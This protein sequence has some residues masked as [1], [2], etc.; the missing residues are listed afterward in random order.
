MLF[1][2]Q[3]WSGSNLELS[4]S[5]S[6]KSFHQD[7]L[8]NQSGFTED[9]VY[10]NSTGEVNV[11]RPHI[12][13]V[14]PSQGLLMARTG[15]CSVSI[16]SDDQV[17]LIGGRVDPNPQQQNDEVP[18][19]LIEIFDNINKTW[20]PSQYSLPFA[21]QYCEAEK[22]GNLVVVTGDWARNSNPAEDPSGTVQL[23][24]LDN[25]T[26]FEGTS[27][28]SSDERGLGAMAEANGY[29]YYAGGVR[30]SNGNDA[31][32]KTY[33]Y[34]PQSDQWTRMADMN[35][36][37]A[38]FE[39]VNFHGQLY[40]MGG[41]QG[42]QTWNRQA[43]DYVERYDPSTDT[44]TNLSKLPVARFGWSGTVLNDE[45]VLVGGFNGGAKSEVFH[46]NPIED[47]W[48]KGNDIGY[49]GHFDLI[50]EEI[51]GSIVWAS[52]DSSTY[53]YNSWNQLFSKDTEFQNSS[54]SHSGWVTSPVI[55]LRP[56]QNGRA[57][58]VQFHLQGT[59]T[60]GGELSFQY[61]TS[62]N[63]NSITTK[64][65]QGYDGTINTTFAKGITN[66]NIT[67]SADFIQ[68][69]IKLTVNDMISWDAPD[70]DSMSIKAEHAAFVST[71]PNFFHPNG[72]TIQLQTSHGLFTNGQMYLEIAACNEF[73]STTG[74]WSRLSHDG[75]SFTLSD[76]QNLAPNS[77]GEINS[78]I[79]GETIVNWSIG[80]GE[81]V[82]VS[83]L[84]LKVGTSGEKVTEFVHSSPVEVDN[85]VEVRISNLGTYSPG[86]AVI[87]GIPINVEVT[88][89]FP[90]TG[91]M[92]SGG[93]LEARIN[94]DIQVNNVTDGTNSG[95]LNQTTPW[96]NL[97][98]GG[99]ST[100]SWTP[101]TDVSGTIEIT[102]EGR[103]SQA[104]QISTD[105]N[106]SNLILDNEGSIILSSIPSNEE[107]LDSQ[108]NRHLT[109]LIADISG[110]EIDDIAMEIWVQ[111]LDDGSDG[112]SPDQI[113]QETEYR[114]IN[115]TMENDGIFWWFNATQSDDENQDQQRVYMRIVGDDL[116][117]NELLDCTVWWKTRD[118]ETAVVER[119]YSPNNNQYWEVSRDISW[120][121]VITDV[122]GL[123]DI[124]SVKIELGGDSEFGI[125]YQ[126]ADMTCSSLG[127]NIDSDRSTCSHSFSGDEMIFSTTLY[128]GW[129]VD[130]SNLD[131]GK[132]EITVSD[133]DGN[134][135][136]TFENLWTF[137]DD[138]DFSILQISDISGPITGDI[139]NESIVQ[140][141]EHIQIIGNVSHSLSGL[142]YEGE[143]SLTWW[144][145][146]QGANWFGS[147]NVEVI[148]GQINTTIAMPSSGGQ[149]DFQISFMDPWGTRTIEELKIPVF[150][151]DAIAPVILDSSYDE[152][153]R[154]HLDDVG[155]GV[156]I[157][158]DVSWTED[159]ELTCRVKSTE[160]NWEPVTIST[161]PT[162]VFQ[163]RTLFSFEFDFS[164]QGDPSL[165][166]PEAQLECWASGM[167]DSGWNLTTESQTEQWLIVPLTSDGPNIELVSV[168]LEGEIEAGKELRAEITVRNS[169]ESLVEPFNITVYTVTEGEKTLVGRFS[170]T[171]ISS[172]QGLVK[173][174]AVKI[175]EGDWELLVVVDEDQKIWEI[176]E[177]DNTY[178]KKYAAADVVSSSIY[179][180]GAS[181]LGLILIIAMILK[182]RS[183]NEIEEAKKMPSL[184]ELPKS[185]PPQISRA[186]QTNNTPVKPKRGPPP[187]TIQDPVPVTNVADAMAKLSLSS[188]PG[189][190]NNIPQR[191]T[192]YES[193]P[194]GGEY[195]YLTEGTFYSG[196]GIGKWKLEEDG[197][198]TRVE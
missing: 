19:D 176:N 124:I 67:D 195:Q 197:S 38:S 118:A 146:L 37:R 145:L 196:E 81:L 151:V 181:G 74:E 58:P 164:G 111:E 172:G 132:V 128:A 36:P 127:T 156:S 83:H 6:S 84:C 66:L 70:L 193:L 191:V 22:V 26:W 86:D 11:N 43:L 92:L 80:L 57:V 61:R 123:S 40:A 190:S 12:Q 62:S 9:G 139:T 14:T 150:T 29:V 187:K 48:S 53:A 161:K 54:D 27:M 56:N 121:I 194:H 41:F 115:F 3:G 158:E 31:T 167:D 147:S 192:S 106:S 165:L 159:L 51:N 76:Q 59:N 170:Q 35:Q 185:G 180:I 168:K 94:F 33:R 17:W 96:T 1:L 107:Y 134:S 47:T 117:G 184:E 100:I 93:D 21:Q 69:R 85:L 88:Q 15:A 126:V 154:Y 7:Q 89:I 75:A 10:T 119:I 105:S 99:D 5:N 18:T 20:Q 140:T 13:W 45:I 155:I 50:V 95:W 28:P 55:D 24:N 60:P 166:S 116:A 23:F 63:S 101:P 77:D 143:L 114:E 25:N 68:Y 39:L 113:P 182:R 173:R 73:G 175:P 4:T 152:L 148:N 112:S 125:N 186:T 97:S 104:L 98:E 130:L 16:D 120:D 136:T 179:V 8:F 2:L 149:M 133:I 34:N 188:L 90:S 71:L 178:S 32:N 157:V 52:G 72:E 142:P 109:I 103:S 65:W 64:L 49:N 141:N 183:G 91:M 162:N 177:D 110:F 135:I 87:G 78:T 198:F 46:W 144:G 42:T 137:S 153:S 171:Q 44:W 138:F 189:K 30:N 108:E 169:G 174:V 82:G 131:E 163:G 129:E 160:V 102:I 122:N 79:T